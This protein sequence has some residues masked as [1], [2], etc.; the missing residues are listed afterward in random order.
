MTEILKGAPVAAALT[1][2]LSRRAEALRLKGVAPCLAIVRLGGRD[3]DLAYERAAM[4]RC[5]AIGIAVRQVILPEDADTE[6]SLRLM[7]LW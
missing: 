4:K 3:D 1:E 5:D 2:E 7:D 6:L